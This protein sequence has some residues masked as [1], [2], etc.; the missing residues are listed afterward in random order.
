[1]RPLICKKCVQKFC[2]KIA[3]VASNRDANYLIYL[4]ITDNKTCLNM[5]HNKCCIYLFKQLCSNKYFTHINQHIYGMLL[6]INTKYHKILKEYTN[7]LKMFNENLERTIYD[8]QY[9]RCGDICKSLDMQTLKKIHHLFDITIANG[10]EAVIEYIHEHNVDIDTYYL[11]Y[12][13][14]LNCPN[15]Q[16]NAFMI[17]NKIDMNKYINRIVD[18][19]VTKQLMFSEY[20]YFEYFEKSQITDYLTEEHVNIINKIQHKTH[21]DVKYINIVNSIAKC[22]YSYTPLYHAVLYCSGTDNNLS[23]EIYEQYRQSIHVTI[24]M[25]T[26]KP[27]YKCVI[28]ARQRYY[29]SYNCSA[30]T[31]KMIDKYIPNDEDINNTPRIFVYKFVELPLS[32]KYELDDIVTLNLPLLILLDAPY[33]TKDKTCTVY[34]YYKMAE[35]GIDRLNLNMPQIRNVHKMKDSILSV[36]DYSGRKDFNEYYSCKNYL[37]Y[38]LDTFTLNTV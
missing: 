14:S 3:S 20:D 32:R 8:N 1:M 31:F 15:I 27:D 26:T 2:H 11:L 29:N 35:L 16:L 17:N 36:Y 30:L 21:N 9:H 22:C 19:Y 5:K 24:S 34:E 7:V 10:I 33:K 6:R 28:L 38:V 4:F 13:C 18:I 12:L 23:E 37:D 25:W